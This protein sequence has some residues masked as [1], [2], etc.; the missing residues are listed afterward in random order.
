MQKI[1]LNFILSGLNMNKY[2]ELYVN[3]FNRSIFCIKTS[4]ICLKLI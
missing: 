2:K 4:I 3:C 1:L